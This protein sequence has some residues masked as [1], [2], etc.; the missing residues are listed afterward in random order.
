MD[1]NKPINDNQFMLCTSEPLALT[2]LALSCTINSTRCA[3]LAGL[4]NK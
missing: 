3:A 1:V 2:A 4:L